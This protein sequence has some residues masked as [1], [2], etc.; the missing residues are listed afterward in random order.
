MAD[1]TIAML[2]LIASGGSGWLASWLFDQLRILISMP[3]RQQWQDG[4]WQQRLIWQLIYHPRS[5]QV[6][7]LVLAS[8]FGFVASVA[9]AWLSGEDMRIAVDTAVN[10][11]FLAPAL[12]YLRH[13]RT[14]MGL[15][16]KLSEEERPVQG[17]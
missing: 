8:V 6:I 11:F 3:T 9:A 14:K 5:A 13:Q 7:N 12:S 1:T 10:T 16:T 4:T 17:A 15:H 2:T